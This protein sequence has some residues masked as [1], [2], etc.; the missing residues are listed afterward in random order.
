[1]LYLSDSEYSELPSNLRR[2]IEAYSRCRIKTE[3]ERLRLVALVH[4]H[5]GLHSAPVCY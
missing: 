2:Q 3:S 5:I 1:M 4:R